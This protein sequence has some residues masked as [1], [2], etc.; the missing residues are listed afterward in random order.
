MAGTVPISTL[1]GIWIYISFYLSYDLI[2][3][4]LNSAQRKAITYKIK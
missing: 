1:E 4:T 2:E 3:V